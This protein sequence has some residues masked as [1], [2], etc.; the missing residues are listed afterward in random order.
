L[1]PGF[2]F[3]LSVRFVYA[4]R[5]KVVRFDSVEKCAVGFGAGGG[6]VVVG[7]GVVV[8]GGASAAAAGEAATRAPTSPRMAIRRMR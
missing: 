2:D 4:Q 1:P 7:A 8:A 3:A 6:V 5:V